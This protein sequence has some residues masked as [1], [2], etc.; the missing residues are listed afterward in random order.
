MPTDA[1]HREIAR[2]QAEQDE[3]NTAKLRK[4]PS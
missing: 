2:L 1:L 4:K 3:K